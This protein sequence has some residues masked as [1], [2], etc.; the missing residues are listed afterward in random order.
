SGINNTD[1]PG[2]TP[3]CAGSGSSG[4]CFAGCTGIG[5]CRDDYVCANITGTPTAACVPTGASECDPIM[6]PRPSGRKCMNGQRCVDYSTDNSY[7][8]CADVCDPVAQDC[9]P[10]MQGANGCVADFQINDGT[11]ECIN[12]DDTSM[13]G[14]PCTFLNDCAAGYMCYA[15]KCRQ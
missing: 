10:A 6:D 2:D 3:V 8:G 14:A 15:Q 13:E 5:D 12:V 4:T 7:G 1:C 11:G 9:A